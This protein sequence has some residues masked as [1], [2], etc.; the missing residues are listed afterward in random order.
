MDQLDAKAIYDEWSKLLG[1]KGS[2]YKKMK[3]HRPVLRSSDGCRFRPSA[4]ATA[5]PSDA[6]GE[7]V[8]GK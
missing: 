8:G 1:E 2:V 4:S 7:F 5:Q 3:T 6:S